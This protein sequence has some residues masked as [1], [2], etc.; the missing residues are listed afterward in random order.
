MSMS[1]VAQGLRP[2]GPSVTLPAS[3]WGPSVQ[4]AGLDPVKLSLWTPGSGSGG[5]QVLL[6]RG[7]LFLPSGSR[8]MGVCRGQALT[9]P[10]LN[11]ERGQ[12][13]SRI[14]S[15]AFMG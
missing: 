14:N 10:L 3:S 2:Q 1:V 12:G 13:T 7:P 4:E 9:N 6:L 11:L 5:P 8:I 15:L